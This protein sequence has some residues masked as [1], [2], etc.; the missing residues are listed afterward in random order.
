MASDTSNKRDEYRLVE[1]AEMEG[2]MERCMLTVGTEVSH[3]KSL[4]ACLIAADYR[5]HFSHGLNR[6]GFNSYLL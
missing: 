4:A 1:K 2:F 5:G 6:L 3:A